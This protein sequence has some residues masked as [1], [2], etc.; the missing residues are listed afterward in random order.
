MTRRQTTIIRCDGAGCR[1]VGEVESLDL[2][3][4]G[5]YR[6]YLVDEMGKQKPTSSFDFHSLRCV[7]KWAKERRM[8]VEGNGHITSPAAT[9]L[10]ST[11]N[12]LEGIEFTSTDLQE[13]TG[14]AQSSVDRYLRQ[15][16]EAGKIVDNGMKMKARRY[17]QVQPIGDVG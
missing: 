8:A 15:W 3:P 1:E 9:Q 12:E 14:I 6:V 11:I 5:W 2:T 16:V 4:S 10:A 7:E 17:R 13:L